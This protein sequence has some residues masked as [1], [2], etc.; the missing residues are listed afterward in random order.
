MENEITRSIVPIDL[1]DEMQKSF[2]AYAM[3]VIINRALPD[4]RDGLKPVHRRILYSMRELS[5]TPDKAY[6]KSARLVGDVLGK[7]HPH[8][9]SAV[10]DAMVRLAQDF[11]IRHMLVDGHGNFGSVDGDGAAAM[12]YTE[13]RMARITLEMLR[14]IDKD[15]VDFKPNFDGREQEPVVLPARFPNLLVNGSGGIAVG[16]ATNIPPHNLAE[17]VNAAIALIDNPEISIDEL[18]TELPGPD[19]PTGGIICG[20]SG[21][22]AAYKTGRGRVRVRART[23]IETYSGDRERIIVT[24]IPYQVNKAV[25]IEKIANLVHAKTVEGISGLRDESDKNGMRIVIELKR[26]ANS[27]VVLNQLYKHTQ[28]QDTFGIIMI[29]LV[30]DEPRVLNLKEILGHYLDHQRTVIVRRTKYE[31]EKARK[32][33]HVLEGLI[34]ALDNIDEVIRLLRTS[35]DPPAARTG[36]M[37][38]FGLSEVQAQAILDMRLQRLTGLE[39]DKILTEHAE[40]VA[41]IEHYEL[42]LS[43]PKMIDDIIKEDLAE[44]RDK[45]AD[46]RRTEITFEEDEIDLDELIEREEMVVTMTHFGYVKRVSLET[47]HAQKRGGKGIS[48][49]ST[50]E[51]DFAERV[52]V[53]STHDNLLF[54]TNKGKVFVKKCYNLPESGRTAKGTAIVNLLQLDSGEK[55][56]TVFPSPKINEEAN[57]VIVTRQ[58]RIKKTT[59]AE[60]RNIRQNGLKAVNLVDDDEL[61]AV[62]ETGGDDEI[63]VATRN[64]MGIIFNEADVRNMGRAAAGVRAIKLR[65]GDEVVGAAQAGE[66]QG[67]QLLVVT[68]NGYGKRT[69]LQEFTAQRRGGYGR[70]AIN[71]TEKTGRVVGVK[72]VDGTEDIMLI[73]NHGV[74]IRMNVADI[75]VIGRSTQGVIVMRTEEDSH[76]VSVEKIVENEADTDV[77]D[78]DHLD[79]EALAEDVK[80]PEPEQ[81]H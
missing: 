67:S 30:D 60:F 19:F 6:S 66:G 39:R 51:E 1:N 23:E 52:F 20:V 47:Y 74:V 77:E 50:R 58:G 64:G 63:L 15:T 62:L 14:D 28:M 49:M 37:E 55:V 80:A 78:I 73:N 41:T 5:M 33:A 2:I 24:E 79:R 43:T 11:S 9:D 10:Y 35:A 34:I 12:R 61:V 18:M 65:E 40:L 53:S 16:M 22:R 21:I 70:K 57:L 56:T 31:L 25:L 42:I 45:Y 32:R 4:V 7:Y 54:F 3:A 26:G 71:V 29:A 38:R 17:T 8:G 48:G 81:V 46:A 13:A 68:E 59:A 44:I 69:E 72:I 36:L 27:S 75:R 76:V